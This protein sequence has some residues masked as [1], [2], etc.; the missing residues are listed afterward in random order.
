M[1]LKAQFL[2][3]ALYFSLF[4]LLLLSTGCE[5]HFLSRETRVCTYT[6]SGHWVWLP[7]PD[8]TSVSAWHTLVKAER[9]H[10]AVGDNIRPLCT[11]PD[12]DS[13]A[14]PWKLV[15]ILALGTMTS[16]IPLRSAN[17]SGRIKSSWFHSQVTLRSPDVVAHLAWND[18]ALLKSVEW[19]CWGSLSPPDDQVF[20]CKPL[21]AL[22]PTA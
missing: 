10:P 6:L 16:S 22:L 20:H 15:S 19:F 4:V 3:T 1:E 18:T 21:G 17:C 14:Y 5:G 2:Y 11:C 8:N 9:P 7:P 13:T 12:T